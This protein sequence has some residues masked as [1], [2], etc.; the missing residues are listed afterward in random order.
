MTRNTRFGMNTSH[1]IK[2]LIKTLS[3]AVNFVPLMALE[4]PITF[5]EHTLY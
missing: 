1:S 2:L 5:D 4:S 3:V